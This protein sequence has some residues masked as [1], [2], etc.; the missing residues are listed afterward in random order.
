MDDG[1][2]V[3]RATP[4]TV[5]VVDTVGA[6]DAFCGGFCDALAREL[7]LQ[8]AIEWAT[9]SGALATTKEGAQPSMPQASAVRSL[10]TERR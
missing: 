3:A 9:A 4:P 6:G 1:S 2:V 5:D 8:E 10:L 7:P